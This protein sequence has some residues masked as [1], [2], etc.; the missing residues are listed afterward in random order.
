MGTCT[1]TKTLSYSQWAGH[2]KKYSG[3]LTTGSSF[4][5]WS[6]RAAYGAPKPVT[7][8]VYS[9]IP[10]ETY[11]FISWMLALYGWHY[12]LL[13][14]SMLTVPPWTTAAWPLSACGDTLKRNSAFSLGKWPLVM[15]W[16]SQRCTHTLDTNLQNTQL[17]LKGTNIFGHHISLVSAFI[18]LFLTKW[19]VC[20][21]S[22]LQ[23]DP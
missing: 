3:K 18:W 7:A 1:I 23:R 15:R 8:S 20:N 9:G 17:L 10:L 22:A 2:I 13:Q 12:G 4:S 11:I 14:A 21:S 5:K 6:L 16:A 19:Q